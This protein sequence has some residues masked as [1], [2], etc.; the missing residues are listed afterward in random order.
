MYRLRTKSKF[1]GE[2]NV[3]LIISDD[4]IAKYARNA[5]T[6]H[7]KNLVELGEDRYLTTLMNKHFMHLFYVYEPSA[8]AR[9]RGSDSGSAFFTQRR[10]WVNS[11]IHNNLELVAQSSPRN[12]F[13][14][15]PM[16]FFF[17]VELF[18]TFVMPA[19]AGSFGYLTYKVATRTGGR[20]ADISLI[21]VT[22]SYGAKMISFIVSKR[23]DLVGW[24]IIH[25][26]SFPLWWIV[27]PVVAFW[28]MD[29]FSWGS[30]GGALGVV[31]AAVD[32]CR[33]WRE[34]ERIVAA[35]QHN[36]GY[37]IATM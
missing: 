3:P 7:E 33:S 37:W 21:M 27:L 12:C 13:D 18:G 17:F 26:I 4:I 28:K 15:F 32:C 16:R 23:W 19:M 1:A 6:L 34:L 30:E 20:E 22:G 9:T 25:V 5:S 35:A 24:M 31:V 36:F 29:D 2:N 10:R 8:T 14:L 11:S